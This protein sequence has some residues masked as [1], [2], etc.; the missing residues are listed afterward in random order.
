MIQIGTN[1]I[2]SDN[3]GARKAMCI[4]LYNGFQSSFAGIGDIVLVT[5]KRLRAKRRNLSKAKKGSMYK[6]L[7]IRVKV[8]NKSYNS[9]YHF[10]ENS[11]V[12]L[13]QKN[14]LLGTRIFGALSKKFRYTKF[15]KLITLSSGLL[16]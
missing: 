14:K 12:L 11:V 2:V 15:S 16:I 4:G 13:N 5:I 6:A 3:S 7:V 9:S 8:I 1:V 10:N